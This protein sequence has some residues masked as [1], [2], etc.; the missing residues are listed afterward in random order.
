MNYSKTPLI[1]LEHELLDA[2]RNVGELRA[3]ID[4]RRATLSRPNGAVTM[5]DT[6]LPLENLSTTA[7]RITPAAAGVLVTDC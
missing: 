2:E 5:R 4:R 3:E 7:G 6:R 1:A